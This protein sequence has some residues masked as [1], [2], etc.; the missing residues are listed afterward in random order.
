LFISHD[1][2]VVEHVSHRMMVMY[3]GKV[4]EIG[5]TKRICQTPKHPYTQA[6]ISAVL[7]IDPHSKR[8]RIVLSG[9]PPSPISPPSG[10]PFHPRCPIA[11]D[12]CRTTAP[13]LR[14]VSEDH[15]VACHLA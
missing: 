15:Q 6:L 2:A 5:D 13:E 11:E 8:R 3:L 7:D 9:E 4:V 1:L 12:R 10:C 14:Q